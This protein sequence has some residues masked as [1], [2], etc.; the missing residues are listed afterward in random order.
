M[1]S[2]LLAMAAIFVA[3]PSRLAVDYAQ[4]A[5]GSVIPMTGSHL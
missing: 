4:T 3:P 5:H 1:A 2:I